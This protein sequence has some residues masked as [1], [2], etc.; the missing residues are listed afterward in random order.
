MLGWSDFSSGLDDGDHDFTEF[1]S[2][3]RREAFF[4]ISKAVT[5]Y[6]PT[7][8]SKPRSV[9]RLASQLVRSENIEFNPN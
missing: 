8:A 3:I 5:C 7:K 4:S 6:L 9:S 1:S 2:Q